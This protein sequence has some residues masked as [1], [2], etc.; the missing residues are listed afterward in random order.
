MQWPSGFAVEVGR[1]EEAL[2][3]TYQAHESLVISIIRRYNK[4][5]K[6]YVRRLM[7][8]QVRPDVLHLQ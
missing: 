4:R 1:W 6:L 3:N 5:A 2:T 7:T 8:L